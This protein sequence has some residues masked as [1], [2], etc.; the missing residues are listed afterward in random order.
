MSSEKKLIFSNLVEGQICGKK[1]V[2]LING[3]MS[4]ESI[5]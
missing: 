5:E 3:K 2:F 1:Y 4:Q